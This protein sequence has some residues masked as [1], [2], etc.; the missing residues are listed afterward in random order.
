MGLQDSDEDDNIDDHIEELFAP[1]QR[2]KDVAP[3]APTSSSAATASTT[4]AVIASSAVASSSADGVVLPSPSPAVPSTPAAA[5]AAA[6]AAAIAANWAAGNV[7]AGAAPVGAAA[8]AAANEAAASANADQQQQPQNDELQQKLLLAR[9]R[10]TLLNR[11]RQEDAT[12]QA[13]AAVMR[14]PTGLTPS[15]ISVSSRTLANQMA[16]RLNVR[17]GYRPVEETPAEVEQVTVKRYEVELE[18]NDF[19]QNVRWRLTSREFLGSLSELCDVGISVRGVFMQQR[20]PPPPTPEAAEA[21]ERPLYLLVE[22]LSD[23]NIQN[24]KKE[25]TRVVK[26]ELLRLQSST[27]LNRLP[28]RYKVL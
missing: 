21:A 17:L 2:V 6:A 20:P 10:A 22:S 11:G 13:A 8:S 5:A 26:E 15:S 16:E 7:G 19:P 18:I 12:H 4:G 27:Q 25:I 28:G 1:R 9:Q 23:L 3:G 24:A 14:G